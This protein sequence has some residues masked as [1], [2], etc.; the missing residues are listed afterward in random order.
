[1]SSE[2]ITS[3]RNDCVR[4]NETIACSETSSKTKR[5]NPAKRNDTDSETK[6]QRS[7]RQKWKSDGKAASLHHQN[8]DWEPVEKITF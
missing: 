5:S 7:L 2:T 4:R 1:M 8:T 3:K 6:Q